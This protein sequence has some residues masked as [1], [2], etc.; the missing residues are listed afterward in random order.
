[1]EMPCIDLEILKTK[2][3]P[4]QMNLVGGC[5]ANR[6]GKLRLRASRPTKEKGATQYIWRMIAFIVSPNSQHH[7]MPVGA[8]FYIN[9]SDYSHRTDQYIP[10]LETDHDR[11]TVNKWNQKTWDMMHRGEKRKKY[12][13]EELDPIVDIVIENIPKNQWHGA[14][15]WHK[16]LHG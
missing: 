5:F 4:E 15:R 8:D 7:C 10:R 6:G 16:A 1:M 12:I 9:E 2:L 13:K 3:T 11:E 14:K